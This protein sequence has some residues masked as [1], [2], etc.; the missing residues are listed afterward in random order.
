MV[1]LHMVDD[2]KICCWNMRCYKPL[3]V[4][5]VL[6]ATSALVIMETI[7]YDGI[8]FLSLLIIK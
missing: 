7:T 6:V 8:S 1:V 4:K 5:C 2:K 3:F